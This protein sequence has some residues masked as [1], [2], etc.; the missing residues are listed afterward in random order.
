MLH[1]IIERVDAEAVLI[2]QL[3]SQSRLAVAMVV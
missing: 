1:Y 3:F 2:N